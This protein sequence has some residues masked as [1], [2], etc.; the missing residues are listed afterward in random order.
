MQESTPG[1]G[2]ET[3]TFSALW[4]VFGLVTLSL[5]TVRRNPTVRW[6]ALAVLMATAAKVLIF[7]LA[8]LEGI[9]RAASFLAVGAL[10]LGGALAARRLSAKA[11]P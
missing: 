2:L 3:W 1:G 5:G 11:E 9:V 8:R 4:A 10:F 6:V 7:D